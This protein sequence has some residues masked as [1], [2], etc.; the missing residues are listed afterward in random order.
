MLVL[1][2]LL[3][4]GGVVAAVVG[5]W[6]G[7]WWLVPTG[8][9]A[10]GIGVLVAGLVAAVRRRVAPLRSARRA[11]V[12]APG[13]GGPLA[14][15]RAVPGMIAAPWRGEDAAVPRYQTVLWLLALVYIVWPIDVVPDLLPLLGFG[16]DI[17]VGAWLVSSL[18]AEAGNHVARR[19]APEK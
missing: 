9:I 16:D 8:L 3:V 6:P 4:S 17:G 19:Q 15:V 1:G 12:S 14:R 11:V 18:Y 5:D 2:V 13:A 7:S 10:A